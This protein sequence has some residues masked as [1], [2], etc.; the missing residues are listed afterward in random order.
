MIAQ[1]L[2]T[3]EAADGESAFAFRHALTRDAIYRDLLGPERRR[4]HAAVAKVLAPRADPTL[5]GE[6]GYHH[7]QAGEWEP[8]LHT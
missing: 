2:V 4:L 8:A 1:Q 6:L 5:D 3:E 7:Y